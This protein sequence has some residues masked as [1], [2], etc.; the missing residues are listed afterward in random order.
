MP[1]AQAA[2]VISTVVITAG[3]VLVALITAL[4]AWVSSRGRAKVKPD[5]APLVPPSPLANFSGTQNE[6]MALVIADNQELRDQ[7][8]GLSSRVRAAERT[9]EDALG[10]HSQFQVAVRRYLEQLASSWPGPATMPWPSEAD[11]G[12]LEQ[13]LPRFRPRRPPTQPIPTHT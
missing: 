3:T 9:L 10:H 1:E 7:I 8:N 6:F 5:D 12:L 13:T 4:F 11:L 2:D